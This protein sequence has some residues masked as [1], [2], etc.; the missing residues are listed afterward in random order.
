MPHSSLPSRPEAPHQSASVT[1]TYQLPE[2]TTT[3]PR[4]FGAETGPNIELLTPTTKTVVSLSPTTGKVP[5]NAL[6]PGSAEVPDF[7]REVDGAPD[8]TDVRVPHSQ[9]RPQDSPPITEQAA[10]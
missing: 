7:A 1:L 4:S 6:N 5:N 10:P 9:T 8:M 2:K 3:T